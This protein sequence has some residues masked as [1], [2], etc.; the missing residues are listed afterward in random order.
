MKKFYGILT[1]LMSTFY[2]Y[3][4]AE[5]TEIKTFC[6]Y[7]LATANSIGA[8]GAEWSQTWGY[9][10]WAW[11]DCEDGPKVGFLNEEVVG[12][13]RTHTTGSPRIDA[14]FILTLPFAGELILTALDDDDPSDIAGEITGA[15]TGAFVADLN[16]N[17]ALITDTTITIQFG[18]PLHSYPDA[19]IE[20]TGTTGKF[21]SIQAEGAWEWHVSGTITIARIPSLNPQVN[22]LAALVNSALILHAEEEVVLTGAY[23]RSMP[24]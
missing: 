2:L 12:L 17:H 18:A 14:N 23:L 22:I 1:V 10:P 4:F 5:P 19:L 16:A 13:Q 7:G 20:L 21:K 6:E 11:F 9:D 8:G 15:M 3:S 24:D